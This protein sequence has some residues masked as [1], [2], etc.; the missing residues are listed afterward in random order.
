MSDPISGAFA[1]ATT[2]LSGYVTAGVALVIAILLLGVG[3]R[4]AVRYIRKA[5][6][7]S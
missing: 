3:V 2:Q 4:V 7:A 1:S 5:A 6:S